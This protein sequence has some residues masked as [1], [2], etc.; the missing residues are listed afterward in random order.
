MRGEGIVSLGSGAGQRCILQGLAARRL[1]LT[2]VVGVT[3]EEGDGGAIRRA[4]D[5]PHPGPALD[6]LIALAKDAPLKKLFDFRF[7]QGDLR[8]QRLG[9]RILA[10]LAVIEGDFGSAIERASD[11]LETSGRVLPASTRSTRLCA[12]LLTGWRITGAQAILRREPRVGIANLYLE[13]SAPLYPPCGEAIR[14][15]SLVVLGPGSL[16]TG[17]APLL[18]TLGMR[19]TL[20][21]SRAPI[22]Y[23]CNLMTRPGETDGFTARDHVREA[24]FHLGF[25]VDHILV[26][27]A[28]V[29]SELVAPFANR[30]SEAVEDDLGDDLRAIRG[31]FLQEASL[32]TLARID[33]PERFFLH[34][35]ATRTGAALAAL[36]D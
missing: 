27:T 18:L 21:E 35:D 14:S 22:A 28:P 32:A 5:L 16:L 30:G 25:P 23:V 15:A 12:E 9:N 20:R 11:L 4:L 34:H 19:E 31:N 13:E 6:A 26:N 17:L 2:A 1:P 33:D 36:V 3:G 24:E 7:R 8:G 29:A 10:A